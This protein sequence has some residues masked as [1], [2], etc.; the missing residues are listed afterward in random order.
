MSTVEHVKGSDITGS[1]VRNL[2]I[3]PDCRYKVSINLSVV[4]LNKKH[5]PMVEVIKPY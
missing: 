4:T 2:D 5:F 1:W 3:K